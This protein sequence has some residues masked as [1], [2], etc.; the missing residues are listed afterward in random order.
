MTNF[1]AV[2]IG[3]LIMKILL[4]PI[5]VYFFPGNTTNLASDNG[6]LSHNP[7]PLEIFIFYDDSTSTVSQEITIGGTSIAANTNALGRLPDG[8]K[9]VE[10]VDKG[11]SPMHIDLT[12]GL[13][14][15]Y[16]V[17]E[18]VDGYVVYNE[19]FRGEDAE[20]Q[21]YAAMKNKSLRK[22]A[23]TTWSS[24]AMTIPEIW[25]QYCKGRKYVDLML[26]DIDRANYLISETFGMGQDGL[27]QH[28]QRDAV[29]GRHSRPW[30]VL[31]HAT[32]QNSAASL[33]LPIKADLESL[34]VGTQ[35]ELNRYS[36]WNFRRHV[37]M[38]IKPEGP[39]AAIVFRQDKPYSQSGHPV[40]QVKSS[41][42]ATSP[43]FLLFL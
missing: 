2:F 28:W 11:Y 23:R 5:G 7:T 43:V 10:L 14:E 6:P 31:S 27:G 26:A 41:T 20:G 1:V 19:T 40:Q 4:T 18:T 3:V 33:L 22:R 37:N 25:A 15:L 39:G 17:V 8:G 9:Y 35:G 29:V 24:P 13:G 21:Y 38:N 16:Q 34:V 42:R 30:S 12:D 36:S 32:D